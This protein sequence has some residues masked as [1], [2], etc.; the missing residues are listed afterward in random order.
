MDRPRRRNMV[1]DL[2]SMDD[3][4]RFWL[5]AGDLDEDDRQALEVAR[6]VLTDVI[7]RQ[8]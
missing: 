5:D 2:R 8:V 7:T 6:D 3:K 4:I 1:L